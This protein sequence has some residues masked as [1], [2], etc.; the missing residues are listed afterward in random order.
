VAVGVVIVK[1]RAATL[2]IAVN[3]RIEMRA[4]EV[5]VAKAA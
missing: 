5:L 3:A 1:T 2:D 4:A